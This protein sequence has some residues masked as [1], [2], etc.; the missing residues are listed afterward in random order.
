MIA[1][2][3][4]LFAV[5]EGNY[6]IITGYEDESRKQWYTGTAEISKHG[7][8]YHMSWDY[9]MNGIEYQDIGMGLRDQN[10]ISFVFKSMPGQ[11]DHY[12]GLQMYN[13]KG[14]I[15]E[16]SYIMFDSKDIGFEKIKRTN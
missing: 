2:L 16:G 6:E 11:A 3:A 1:H 8:I 5:I 14:D 7:D 9:V 12:E 13:I 15:L 10:V 4:V